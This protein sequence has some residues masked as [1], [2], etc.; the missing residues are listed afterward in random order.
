MFLAEQVSSLTRP[1]RSDSVPYS[2]NWYLDL[3]IWNDFAQTWR[4]QNVDGLRLSCPSG[5]MLALKSLLLSRRAEDYLLRDCSKPLTLK[6][7]ISRTP[8]YLQRMPRFPSRWV[9]TRSSEWIFQPKSEE[10]FHF[11]KQNPQSEGVNQNRAEATSKSTV[12]CI[13]RE[14]VPSR[15]YW[16]TNEKT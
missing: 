2:S 12:Y 15:L 7:T 10:R 8:V 9:P 1:S 5:S 14:K 6:S 3:D 13:I 11:I 16:Y 4:V